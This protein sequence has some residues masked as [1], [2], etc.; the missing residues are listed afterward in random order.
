MRKIHIILFITLMSLGFVGCVDNNSFGDNYVPSLSVHYLY[1]PTTNLSFEADKN[2]QKELKIESENTPW[3]FSGQADWVAM[4]QS[5][6]NANANIRVTAL[7]NT[8]G[9][10]GRSC[11]FYFD[12]TDP[13][14]SYNKPITISQESAK[15]FINLSINKLTFSASSS[16][17]TILIESN[18]NWTISCSNDWVSFAIS[19][20]KSSIEISVKE[21]L[22][23]E[24]R[25]AS[26]FINGAVTEVVE[27]HQ[28]APG[29]PVTDVTRIDFNQEGGHHNVQLTSDVSWSVSTSHS[30]IE[31]SPKTGNSGASEITIMVT[32]NSTTNERTGL[33]DIIIGGRV[34]RTIEIYQQGYYIDIDKEKE[35]TS[36]SHSFNLKLNTNVDWTV[37]S[38]PDWLTISPNSGN[39]SITEL[40]V[41]PSENLNMA[42]RV[43]NISVGNKD[44]GLAVTCRVVQKGKYFNDLIKSV[45]FNASASNQDIEIPTDA[46]WTAIPN[47]DWIT[48]SPK[49]GKGGI[50]NI[51]VTENKCDVERNGAIEITVGNITKSV[52]VNQKG[53]YLI[54]HPTESNEI[55]SKGG[56]HQIYVSSDDIWTA[57]CDL[58]WVTLSEKQ[59]IGDINVTLIISDNPSI[60]ERSGEVVFNTQYTQPVKIIV[61]QAGRYLRVNTKYIYFYKKGG[62]SDNV[63]IDTD[64][65]VE[66]SSS[67]SWFAVSRSGNIFSIY[68]SPNNTNVSRNGLVTLKLIDITDPEPYHIS[69]PVYQY[70]EGGNFT[71]EDFEEDND[72]NP[73]K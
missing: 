7:K 15:P 49:S 45:Q 9:D 70:A 16:S 12:S 71:R 28:L 29:I 48:L 31:V 72:W 46:N 8:S 27:I 44:L 40:K 30:W 38:S 10:S 35:I 68:A 65:S 53:K 54:V 64:G 26:I 1:T 60:K 39:S 73:N 47:A 66:V 3:E 24:S 6:G 57:Q 11:I 59:G 52:I 5:S 50:M 36:L 19:E 56:S 37:L 17:S 23:P 67:D 69:I 42:E 4:S 2:L 33:V 13:T 61:N 20:D 41:T 51:S 58:S 63:I 21:N 25:T 18:I 14:Y 62:N 32:P 55:S 34:L 43:G 22:M